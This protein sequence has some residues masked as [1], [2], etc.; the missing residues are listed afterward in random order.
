MSDF[1]SGHR[2]ERAVAQGLVGPQWRLEHVDNVAGGDWPQ[3]LDVRLAAT[4]EAKV[5][6]ANGE[7][8]QLRNVAVGVPA[9]D[10]KSSVRLLVRAPLLRVC[11][12]ATRASCR[13]RHVTICERHRPN[14]QPHNHKTGAL[15]S[16]GKLAIA[17]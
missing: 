14:L 12:K 6:V 2:V 1:G 13:L 7:R 11:D 15:K 5:D 16:A 17:E 10:M 3:R 9:L 8:V 4:A